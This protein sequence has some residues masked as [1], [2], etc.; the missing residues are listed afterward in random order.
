M[1]TLGYYN[2]KYGTL[3]EM[4]VPF[5]DRGHFFG[6]GVYEVAMVRNY[7]LYAFDEHIERFY[8]SAS[9]LDIKIP[10]TK[11]EL[12]EIDPST[13]APLHEKD[14]KRIIRG[15]EVFYST[16]ITLTEFKAKSKT[17]SS[18]YDFL[19]IQPNHHL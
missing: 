10:Y 5:N 15:L 3:E 13:A 9:Q 1:K 2:G 17:K 11:E 6:D 18:K 4:T 14:L 19:K 12:R 8:S 16:G 7:K